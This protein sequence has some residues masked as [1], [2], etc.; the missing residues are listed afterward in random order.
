MGKLPSQREVADEM[1]DAEM[2]RRARGD[3][4]YDPP[5]KTFYHRFTDAFDRGESE[6]K[7]GKY[8]DAAKSYGQAITFGRISRITGFFGLSPSKSYVEL[9]KTKRQEALKKVDGSEGNGRKGSLKKA[10]EDRAMTYENGGGSA[11]NWIFIIAMA[12]LLGAIFIFYSNFT[13]NVIG[14]NI[15]STS[16]LVGGAL[17]IIGIVGSFAC[18][19]K[20]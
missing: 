18:L 10:L 11:G 16:N 1:H 13:S 6:F 19:R 14:T 17:F 20:Q 2:K 5:Y 3:E 12:G 15:N 9:A 7:A 4:V 8:A